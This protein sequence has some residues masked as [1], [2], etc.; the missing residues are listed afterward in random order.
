M[1]GLP[2]VLVVDDDESIRESICGVLADLG[3]NALAARNGREALELLRA[4]EQRPGLILLDMMMPVMN[5][6]QFLEERRRD[7]AL[8]AIPVVVMTA[9]VEASVDLSEVKQLMRKPLSYEQ[10]VTVLEIASSASDAH[11]APR[12]SLQK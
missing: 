2:L 6:W 1:S 7:D 10:L 12:R 5:G 9:A 11:E 3:C 8:L 4:L